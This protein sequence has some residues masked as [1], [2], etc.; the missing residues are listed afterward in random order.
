[1]TVYNGNRD[2]LLAQAGVNG[3]RKDKQKKRVKSL[4]KKAM[5]W[6]GLCTISVWL[7]CGD[8][9]KKKYPILF[10]HYSGIS[11][12]TEYYTGFTPWS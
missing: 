10:V 5:I 6:V 12:S 8:T 3:K 4:E 1:M 11:G 2:V 9:G 7:N